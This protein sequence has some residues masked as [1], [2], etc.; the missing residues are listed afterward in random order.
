MEQPELHELQCRLAAYNAGYAPQMQWQPYLMRRGRP[1]IESPHQSTDT[2][3]FRLS[4]SGGEVC[5]VDEILQDRGPKGIVLGNST[6]FGVNCSR[7][8]AV[9]ASQLIGLSGRR[10]Y[11]FSGRAYTLSQEVIAASLHPATDL[12]W[13][14]SLSGVNELTFFL[15]GAFADDLNS[16][17]GAPEFCKRMNARARPIL[18][19]SFIFLKRER[20]NA[21]PTEAS[22][23]RMLETVKKRLLAMSILARGYGARLL[24]VMQ[25]VLGIATKPMTPEE[26]E[27]VKASDNSLDTKSLQVLAPQILGPWFERYEGDVSAFCGQ[28][29]IAYVNASTSA[30]LSTAEWNWWDRIHLTDRG[31]QLLAEDIW[32]ALDAS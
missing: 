6:A 22:Y 17:G 14:V 24:F 27:L 2:L 11:N 23:G 25:P 28:A 26:L 7:D 12:K 18:G 9:V 21:A 19:G 15:L 29:R 16:F 30:R 20:T 10:W 13:M 1:C 5:R 3:G 31:H 4:R 8:N 32:E